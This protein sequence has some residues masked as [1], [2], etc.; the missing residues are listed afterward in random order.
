MPKSSPKPQF[1]GRRQLRERQGHHGTVPGSHHGTI[2]GSHHGSVPGS[3]GSVGKETHCTIATMNYPGPNLGRS[4]LHAERRE[5]G[6]SD[7][8]IIDH[9]PDTPQGKVPGA[10]QQFDDRDLGL[11][12]SCAMMSGQKSPSSSPG[13][14]D[15]PVQHV[16]RAG[17]AQALPIGTPAKEATGRSEYEQDLAEVIT[18]GGH[19]EA[20]QHKPTSK[21]VCPSVPKGSC[22]RPTL[23]SRDSFAE[24]DDDSAAT[25]DLFWSPSAVSALTQLRG[26]ASSFQESSQRQF[27][28]RGHVGTGCSSPVVSLFEE[29]D[30]ERPLRSVQHIK[31]RAGFNGAKAASCIDSHGETGL[32]GRE[33]SF[34]PPE[35]RP[36][37]HSIPFRKGIKPASAGLVVATQAKTSKE[38][39]E[40]EIGD[41][42]GKQLILRLNAH[43]VLWQLAKTMST[44]YSIKL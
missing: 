16:Y 25:Q 13:D 21:H 7:V 41:E 36:G 30:H 18:I 20:I 9:P 2:P 14:N 5:G 23:S 15:S 1:Q 12:N 10:N 39:G 38:R 34:R 17:K 4:P 37:S 28:P 32:T 26:H 11:E 44:P 3:H 29:G 43:L 27:L 35:E 8:V 22:G 31:H 33:T 42:R 24:S 19:E 6:D 40:H